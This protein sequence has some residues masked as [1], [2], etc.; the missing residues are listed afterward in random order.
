[1]FYFQNVNVIK[2]KII[3]VIMSIVDKSMMEASQGGKGKVGV[4]DRCL[5]FLKRRKY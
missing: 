3:P 1:M 2:K 4:R 5:G